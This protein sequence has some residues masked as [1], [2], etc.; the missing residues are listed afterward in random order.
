MIYYLLTD[1]TSYKCEEKGNKVLY[2][3]YKS[4]PWESSSKIKWKTK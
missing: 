4:N 2:D 3:L 1:G